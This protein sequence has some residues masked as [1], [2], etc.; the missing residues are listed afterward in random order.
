MRN[1]PM[2][3]ASLAV[4]L[5]SLSAQAAT[6]YVSPA[7]NDAWSG[8]GAD[9]PVATL[10]RARDLLRQTKDPSSRVIVADGRYT[11][12]QPFVLTPAD[13]GVVYEAAP[14]ARPVFSG[15]RVIRGFEPAG[16]GLW[17][18]KIDDVADGSWY[19]DQLFVDGRRATRARSPNKFYYYM[20]DV[21]EET[22]VKGSGNRP[23][24]ARQTVTVRP[25]D[26]SPLLEL[27]DREL[28]DVQ[29][30]VYHKWDNTTRFI[31]GLD[32]SESAI[33]TTGEGLK[34]WN[35]WG[36]G[37][38]YHLENF[39]AALDAPGEWF[40]SRDGWLYY[41]PL[42]GQDMAKAEVVA[43]VVEKF[44]LFEGDV[45]SGKWVENITI[46]G[47]T[48]LHGEYRMPPSGF[49]ASQAAS[50][51]DA[52]VMA[53]GA[54]YVTIEDCEFGHFGRYG[55]WFR[56]GC[57]DCALRKSY[58]HDFGAG[59]VRIG[60]S[61]V[62]KSEREQTGHITLDNNI[63]RHG[64]RIFPSAVG[65]WIGH[66]GDN[67]VMH[68]EIAD[69]YYT[70]I[71]VGWIWGYSGSLAKRN[72][73][74]FNRVHHLGWAVLSD[75]GGIYTLGPS[76]GTV[77]ANNV[78]HDIYAYSYGGWGLYT[79]EGSTGIVMEKNLV[80]NTKTGSFH[81]HYGK[82]N[83][84]R[85]NILVNSLMHQIQATRVEEHLSFTF[86]KNLVFWETGPLLAGPWTQLKVNMDN[87]CYWNAAGKDVTF[88]GMS[89]EQWRQK[90]H[91][92]HSVIA[93]PGFVDTKNL[94]FRLKPDS[95]AFKIGFEPFDYTQAG[96]YGD[97]A[98]TA[99]ANEVTYPS[100]EWPPDPPAM[101]IKDGFEKPAVGAKPSGAEVNIENR[102]DSIEVTD[103]FASS[104]KQSLKITDAPG[105]RNA[106]NPHLVYSPNHR[107]GVTRCSFD[108]RIGAG[109]SI[110]HE[111]RDW[112][113]SPY[114]VG[115]SL[116]INGTN[117]QVAGRN[118]M[119]LP[120]DRWIHFEIAADLGENNSRTWDLAVTLPGEKPRE[121]KGLKAGSNA[122]ERLTWLGF[123]S[124]ATDKTVFYLDNLEVTNQA[125]AP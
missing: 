89:L 2:V 15:G 115:P 17:R 99:K 108:L 6:I 44:V 32:K 107:S 55:V 92:L 76:E 5:G 47:L 105:L 61:T 13:S 39:P 48:F 82:E 46:K 100:L 20:L 16:N 79:D 122:F 22:L 9:V 19:F 35:S 45:Q 30:V 21:Q 70:G 80:Y 14:G 119:T 63:I 86:E 77:I 97:P 1:C 109:V 121:F 54:R 95:P 56:K 85:N 3:I 113:P 41:V 50:P 52:V 123:V 51:I 83:I 60:E 78:F 104:G 36:K 124:N 75:M 11:L 67:T 58:I 120:T 24:R 31:E 65:I 62:P 49:E 64:G 93:D 38:R 66:S 33:V 40:L 8:L 125:S 101:A 112:R 29:M 88:V 117:L 110:N 69:L 57:R 42:E 73:I 7:G 87:N 71:S 90:G 10:E 59:G 116:W 72:N 43:P 74:R 25:A 28:R 98:W 106:F 94:D 118:L 37:D 114:A 23:Q 34:P 53:D 84:I 26:V 27:S 91:D 103:E 96:V 12:P 102:G 4:V 68:N 111:W 18:A 81:Q